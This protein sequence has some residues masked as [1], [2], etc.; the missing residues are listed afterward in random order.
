MNI[1]LLSNRE[2]PHYFICSGHMNIISRVTDIL[3]IRPFKN[4]SDAN[5]W[6]KKNLGKNH[7]AAYATHYVW[8]AMIRM[9]HSFTHKK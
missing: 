7:F 3:E 8:D 9:G 4:A 6:V 5:M 1:E 2:N